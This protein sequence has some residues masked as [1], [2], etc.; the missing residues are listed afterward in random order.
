[1]GNSSSEFVRTDHWLDFVERGEP[2]GPH[3]VLRP[4]SWDCDW[5]PQ[6]EFLASLV[7]CGCHE[8][9][10]EQYG[11]I[12]SKCQANGKSAKEH[13]ISCEGHYRPA[14]EFMLLQLHFIS[15]ESPSTVAS[16]NAAIEDLNQ[17]GL[18]IIERFTF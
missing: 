1:M 10:H 13:R 8:D 14:I 15:L 17:R 12:I 18:K 16:V 5:N 11:Q 6:M 9:A 2:G 3:L 7:V 4:T